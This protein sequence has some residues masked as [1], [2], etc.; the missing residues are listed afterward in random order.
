[1]HKLLYFQ[2]RAKSNIFDAEKFKDVDSIWE[3]M[4]EHF[5]FHAKCI[6]RFAKRVPG[7]RNNESYVLFIMEVI[8]HQ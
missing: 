3:K 2:N 7:E 8:Y 1:M 4:M 6:V 5:H